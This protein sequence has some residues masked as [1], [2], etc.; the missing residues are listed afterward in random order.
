[1]DGG[2]SEEE[3]GIRENALDEVRRDEKAQAIEAPGEPLSRRAGARAE[4]DPVPHRI[5]LAV[6]GQRAAAFR[7]QEDLV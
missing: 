7:D 6:E 5:C 1:M 3:Q 2:E 4:R